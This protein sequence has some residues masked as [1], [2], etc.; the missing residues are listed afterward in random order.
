MRSSASAA[1]C[2]AHLLEFDSV[3]GRWS[4]ACAAEAGHMR[5]GDRRLA[6]SSKPEIADGD[7]SD[8]DIVIEATGRHHKRPDS[9]N[10]YFDQGVK[11]VV[12][13]APTEGAL[14]VVYGINDALYDADRHHLLTAAS[15]TT[16][17]L[18]PAAKVVNDSFGIVKGLMTT[19]HSY[20]NDQR[21]LDLAEGLEHGPG[22]R[23]LAHRV[24]AL[25]PGHVQRR[26]VRR[27]H[28]RT[29]QGRRDRHARPRWR[30]P[31]FPRCVPRAGRPRATRRRRI[32]R[33]MSMNS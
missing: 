7:W 4:Q 3:H 28:R 20:T 25:D 29:Q 18:A 30:R 17:C 16:N 24:A 22:L 32:P 11:K 33:T 6:H 26:I 12:V 9:L 15:C 10:A 27:Q 21:I 2:A 14:N 23:V 1:A 19:V 8:C 5:I 13:A 31:C